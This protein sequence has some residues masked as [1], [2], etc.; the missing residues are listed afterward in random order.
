[1]AMG[2]H[3]SAPVHAQRGSTAHALINRGLNE[4]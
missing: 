3:A 2:V 1:M 4:R